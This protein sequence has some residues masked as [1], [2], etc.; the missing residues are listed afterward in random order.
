MRLWS[1]ALACISL[2]FISSI[3][4]NEGSC[5]TCDAMALEARNLLRD[6]EPDPEG[7]VFR[8]R[9]MRHPRSEL[10]IIKVLDEVRVK[11]TEKEPDLASSLKEYEDNL[12][13]LVYE[14]GPE[15]LP[16][17]LCEVL[18]SSCPPGTY[19]QRKVHVEDEL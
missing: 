18:L 10:E 14:E 8:S 7:N 5:E 19:V 1:C 6:L 11:W 9:R 15:R 2:I 16:W 17:L 13:E 12:E 4:A 3:D